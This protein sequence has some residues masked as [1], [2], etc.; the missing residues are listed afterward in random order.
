MKCTK[1]H[2]KLWAKKVT[3]FECNS[4][5]V[6]FSD[7]KNSNRKKWIIRKICESPFN[8]SSSN[9]FVPHR[10]HFHLQTPT[11]C[12]IFHKMFST[13]QLKIVGARSNFS[14]CHTFVAFVFFVFTIGF[15]KK[16]NQ[17][18]NKN[19]GEPTTNHVGTVMIRILN[20]KVLSLG[21]FFICAQARWNG[22]KI[23][24]VIPIWWA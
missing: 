15:I 23:G 2:C 24:W 10:P 9:R 6:Y 5:A 20:V 1:N 19:G 13:H 12:A 17:K 22:S 3:L 11:G 14:L 8:V 16:H 18:N 4:T 21:T 7:N